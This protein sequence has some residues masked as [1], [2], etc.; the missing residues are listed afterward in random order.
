M[1]KLLIASAALAMVAGSVQAQ[2]S[3]SVYGIFD[4]GY[5]DYDYTNIGASTASTAQKKTAGLNAGGSGAGA[6][7]SNRIGFRGTEDLGGGLKAGF[8]YELGFTPAASTNDTA[9][10]NGTLT[11][12]PRES[13]VSLESAKLGKIELGYGLTGLHSTVAGHRA[14]GGTNFVGDLSYYSDSTATKADSRIHTNAV[15]MSG[16]SYYAPAIMGVT[17]RVDAGNDS[18]VDGDKTQSRARNL[19]VS[20]NYATGP[21]ALAATQHAYYTQAAEDGAATK[22]EFT[23]VSAKYALTSALTLDALYAKRVSENGSTGV[24]ASK[25]DVTQVGVKYTV[26]NTAFTA[27]YGNGDGET[28]SGAGKTDRKGY[29]L[30]ILNSLSKRT[31]AYAMYGNQEGKQVSDGVAEKVSAFAVGLRHSF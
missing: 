23:A 14:N 12:T 11:T 22:Y 5:Q 2:S 15:R 21:L 3:V 19:G 6:L 18:N 31:T 24:Q 8:N 10:N 29:Q 25:D 13:K 1:K 30:G 27:M 4:L 16:V 26:G 17:A 20:L 28:T 9:T 7:S